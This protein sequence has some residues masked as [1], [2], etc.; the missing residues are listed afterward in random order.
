MNRIAVITGAGSGIGKAVAHG[1]M[2]DGWKVALIGRRADA[3]AGTLAGGDGLV[4]P[5]DVR[6]E[7]AIEAA[8]DAC[9]ARFGRIDLLF[10]NAGL[11]GATGPFDILTLDG[12][13]EVIDVNL[14][15]MFLCARAAFRRM[16]AQ[17]PRGGRI[18]NCGSVSAQVPR[19][20]AAPYTASKHGVT[21]LTKAISLDGRPWN[22][23]CGQ[24]DIG[25]AATEMTTGFSAALQPDGSRMAEPVMDVAHVAT[26]VRY[27]A[28]LPL[29][30]NVQTMTVMATAMPLVGRG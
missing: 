9:I 8:F 28:G 7:A 15:G 11:F 25:N 26:A 10:N 17:E 2:A 19:P 4:L 27:M 5:A 16:K 12:W 18:I 14:T 23:A 13:R 21:G 1:L 22:I 30:A 6:D 20:Q 29:D 24:I 3:L